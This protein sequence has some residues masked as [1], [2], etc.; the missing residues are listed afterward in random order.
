MQRRLIR[1]VGALVRQSIIFFQR[2]PRLREA[3]RP[4]ARRLLPTVRQVAAT[5]LAF[6]YQRWLANHDVL[7]AEDRSAI[8]AEVAGWEDPPLLSVVMPAYV[9]QPAML[10]AAIASVRAQLY[11]VWQL[12][13]AD[14]ASPGEEVGKM[15][16][17]IAAEEPRIRW[18]RRGTNGNLSAASNSAF[19]L[20]TGAWVVLMDHDDLLHETSLYRVARE[21][22]AHSDAAV[23]YSDE[24]KIDGNGHRS[25][26]Y[27]KPDF[28]PELFMAQNI[29]SHLACYR[30]DLVARI[31]GFREGFEGG[32]DHDLA[33]RAVAAVAPAA[34]RHIP[35]VL[36][37]WRQAS[38]AQSLSESQLE[39]CVSASRRAV[40][41]VLAAE[42]RGAAVVPNPLTS[43]YHRIVQQ[44][45]D[46]PPLV[47]VIVPTRDRAELLGACLDGVLRRTAYSELEVI[48]VD[49]GS[50]EG[51]TLA[52]FDRLAADPRVRILPVPGSFNYSRL[53]NIAA[54]EARGEVLMLLNNDTEVIDPDWMCEM[55]AQA[56]R[57]AIGAV[58]AKLLY[59]DDRVQHAGV[60]LGLGAVGNVAAHVYQLAARCDPGAFGQLA[61]LRSASAVTAACLA[62][63]RALYLEVG[64]LD[65]NLKVAF[66]DVDFCLRLSEAGY[67]NVW[68]PF[69]VLY[70]RESA[71]RGDDLSGEKAERFKTEMDY[72]RRRWGTAL[73]S[74]PYW[75]PNLSLAT[76]QRDLAQ[77][78]RGDAA[79]PWRTP[80][81][82]PREASIASIRPRGASAAAAAVE[83]S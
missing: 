27:F 37:H 74:D 22:C 7:R 68:T 35:A 10:R 45:P 47:S 41:D 8:T 43:A 76:G 6:A 66:N 1:L 28:D 60:L 21:I 79:A 48:V 23:V 11:P 33:L 18:M 13:I 81:R 75:N 53:N 52:L 44:L 50:T 57:P 40:E 3:I 17:A 5:T 49:N 70:H 69:A 24:D 26:P 16:A 15:L 63:R 46:H 64:G 9:T 54:A 58:G 77:P 83:R 31:G 67:R 59:P 14:D 36:Y 71:S 25:D 72:M 73:E 42:G 51:S 30:R 80:R 65:E 56:L 38:G 78:P 62:V 82:S 4:V 19:A 61:M 32:Q 39:R 12:C 20:A 29:V 2:Y 55:V 34:I